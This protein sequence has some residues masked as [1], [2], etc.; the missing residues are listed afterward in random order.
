MLSWWPALLAILVWWVFSA[1]LPRG[2]PWV[3]VDLDRSGLSRQMLRFV[4]QAPSLHLLAIVPDEGQ[5][6]ALIQR[7]QAL[8]LLVV[9]RGFERQI[10][11]GQATRLPIFVNA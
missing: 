2:L 6:T 9:P 5:A 1:G 11:T 7:G 3:A 4:D 8:G 10:K